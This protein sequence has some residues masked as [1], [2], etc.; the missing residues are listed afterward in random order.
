M[1]VAYRGKPGDGGSPSGGGIGLAVLAVVALAVGLLIWWLRGGQATGTLGA[2]AAAVTIILLAAILLVGSSAACFW[3]LTCPWRAEREK[4]GGDISARNRILRWGGPRRRAWPFIKPI[5]QVV[6]NEGRYLRSRRRLA[7]LWSAE[8]LARRPVG[9]SLSGGGI[10]SAMVGLGVL[11]TLMHRGVLRQVDYLSTVSGGGYIGSALSSLLSARRLEQ[12]PAPEGSGQFAFGPG[13]RPHFDLDPDGV[14]APFAE[15]TPAG[16]GNR[17]PC[18]WL[19]GKMVV[20]H[21]RAFGDYLVRRRRLL[22]RD[23]LRAVGSIGAG[24]GASLSLFAYMMLLVASGLLALIHFNQADAFAAVPLAFGDYLSGLWRGVGGVRFA[25]VTFLSAVLLLA[26][27]AGVWQVQRYCPPLWFKRDGDTAVEAAQYR[28]LWV[29]GGLALVSGLLLCGLLARWLPGVRPN[30]LFPVAFFFGGAIAAGFF[31]VLVEVPGWELPL[32]RPNIRRRSF[33]A[34]SLALCWYLMILAGGLALLPWVVSRVDRLF[35]LTATASLSG[36]AATGFYAWWN[37]RR[38]QREKVKEVIEK[39]AAWLKRTS[40]KLRRLALGCVVAVFLVSTLIL[41]LVFV[42]RGVASLNLPPDRLGAAHGALVAGLSLIFWII[43]VLID[44]NNLSLH[45]FYRDR[46]VEAFLRTEARP[47]K[48]YGRNLELKRDH[49]EMRLTELHGVAAGKHPPRLAGRDSF[50]QYQVGG[51]RRG[52]GC[53]F[54]G[55]S[56][57]ELR[58]FRFSGAATA[59]P[60]HL[61]VT[62]VNLATERD[63]RFRSRKSDIF[64]FSKLYCG[65]SVTGYVDTGVYRSGQTKVARVMTISGA[66]ADSALGRETFFAQSF[67]ATLFNVRLGQW[68]ENPA[69]R[70]GRYV[71]LREN[72]VFWP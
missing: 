60:Y 39:G 22:D 44:F 10:R 28:L 25:L 34:A 29:V 66:A 12:G 16:G 55:A 38:A 14:R 17:K 5:E 7:G 70:A 65:S 8:D 9:V 24:I 42:H 43:G 15:A 41:A 19:D 47:D 61:Y 1:G 62:C 31:F 54:W 18:A 2:V 35:H 45:Y 30:L 13:D 72:G 21:L 40:E 50:V 56:L 48:A 23:L 51:K 49:Q 37:A 67:A 11:Q 68:M 32:L 57:P 20:T 53:P 33:L 36:A 26:T 46:L 59:A 3:L 63:M 69:F 58:P 52:A 71:H 4:V 64:L 27:G 6:R